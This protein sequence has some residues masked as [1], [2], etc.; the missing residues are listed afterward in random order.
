MASSTEQETRLCGN[1]KRDIPLINFTIHEIHCRRNISLCKKC[2]EP[3]PSNDME[4]HMG[5]EHVPVTCK[6]KMTMEKNLLEEHERSS[7]PLRLLLCQFCDLELAFNKLGEHEE[8]CGARTERCEK[9]GSSVMAKDLKDH[10][11]VCGKVTE[12]KKPAR[13]QSHRDPVYEGA[14]FDRFQSRN[15]FT[16]DMFSRMPKHVPARFYGSSVLTRS[17]KTSNEEAER[18][19]MREQNR[20]SPLADGFDDI[21]ADQWEENEEVLR[22]LQEDTFGIPSFSDL[23]QPVTLGNNTDISSQP[24]SSFP[25]RDPDFWSNMYSTDN[26]KRTSHE[27]KNLN[28][29]DSAQQNVPTASSSESTQLPCEFCEELFP[30]ED[31]I[32]HQSGCRLPATSSN[33]RFSPIPRENVRPSSPPVQSSQTVLL[34][35]EF[36]GV[37]LEAE[38]LFHHQDQCEKCPDSGKSSAFTPALLPDDVTR[39]EKPYRTYETSTF[40]SRLG[41]TTVDAGLGTNRYPRENAARPPLPGRT[42]LLTAKRYQPPR[43]NNT[44]RNP[45]LEDTRRKNQEE[46]MRLLRNQRHDNLPS[47]A[48]NRNPGSRNKVTNQKINPEDVDKEE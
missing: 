14:W 32:L 24:E 33:R 46:N 3:V 20:E 13:A 21:T 30:Q 41:P 18:N 36:C 16:D 7:C 44:L 31:L 12:P 4:E 6:C 34:P 1:C 40:Q 42:S 45:V 27:N 23:F 38:I 28:N 39:E 47:G 5:T 10:P 37:L 48:S 25:R 17:F 29:D 19:R 11:D 43:M 26:V 2:K 35:C 8:Y 22:A 15:T 9:C